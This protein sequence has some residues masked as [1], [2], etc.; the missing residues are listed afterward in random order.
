MMGTAGCSLFVAP[1]VLRH[2]VCLYGTE[3][4]SI[5]L[6]TSSQE[7]GGR[8]LAGTML[9]SDPPNAEL[10]E[11]FRLLERATERQMVAVHKI[12][13]PEDATAPQPGN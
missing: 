12:V 2:F 5:S 11:Q 9:F 7:T 13:L 10:I 6:E 8:I 3:K 1:A 4:V